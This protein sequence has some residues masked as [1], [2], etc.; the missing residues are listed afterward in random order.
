MLALRNGEPAGKVDAIFV[1]SYEF[2]S[3][4]A[5]PMVDLRNCNPVLEK[6]V[7]SEKYFAF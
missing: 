2:C 1:K 5:P 4:L 7:T 6:D 3:L